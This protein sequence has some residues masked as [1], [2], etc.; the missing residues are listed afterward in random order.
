MFSK[1]DLEMFSKSDR[2]IDGQ[3]M[4]LRA[5]L[6]S[7]GRAGGAAGFVDIDYHLTWHS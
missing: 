7:N 4:R 2:G 5:A 1:S 6:G 3:V